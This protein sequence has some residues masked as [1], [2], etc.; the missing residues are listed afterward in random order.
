MKKCNLRKLF[1]SVRN[2]ITAEEKADYDSR[3]FTSFINSPIF[4]NASLLLIYVSFGSEAD[5]LNIINFA[6]KSGKRVA[7]PF[8][9]GDLMEFYEISSTENLSEGK[10]GIPTVFPDENKRINDFD[11]T[12][13]V[14][15]ALSFDMSGNRLGYGGGFY[16]RFLCDKQILTV[17]LTY[18]RCLCHFLPA[19]EHDM[20]INFI[21][22]EYRFV[23]L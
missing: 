23:K 16:D 9:N 3:I 5:T 4:L 11:G 21:L 13:C 20:K 15:P 8:C 12:V 18:E 17:G 22:T 14:V 7:V 19:E 10:F 6:L 1:K 2:C